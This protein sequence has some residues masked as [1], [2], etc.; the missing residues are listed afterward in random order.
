[1]HPK[2]FRK[3]LLSE[4]VYHLHGLNEES[5]SLSNLG[6]I[7]IFIG[8]NN[9]GKS[10]FLRTLFRDEKSKKINADL[11]L[12]TINAFINYQ[13][14]RI[15]QLYE[16]SLDRKPGLQIAGRDLSQF[17]FQN[18]S[19]SDIYPDWL[20]KIKSDVNQFHTQIMDGN[21][22]AMGN[23][24]V[25]GEVDAI[26][27][28]LMREVEKW[29]KQIGRIDVSRTKLYIPLL[30]GLRGFEFASPKS[31]ED[32]HDFYDRRTRKDYFNGKGEESDNRKGDI[33]TGLT[34]F[35]ETKAML[36]GD[37][38]DRQRIKEF[39]QFIGETFFGGPDFS[40]IPR[41]DDD[42]VHIKIGDEKDYPIHKLGDGIQAL[43]VLLFPVF[44]NKDK[45][46]SVFFEEPDQSLHPAFQR[47]FLEA[48]SRKEFE[49]CQFFFTTHSNHFLDMTL[50]FSNISVFSFRKNP[51]GEG[52]KFLVQNVESHDWNILEQLGVRNSSV[53]LSNC[54]IWVEGIT[55]RIYIRKYL[56][57]F[58][59]KNGGKFKE[60]LH[61]SFVEYGGGNI[62]HWSFLEENDDE[63]KNINVDKLC[64]KLF[65]VAD[66]D[67]TGQEVSGS[68]SKKK[69]RLEALRK[70]LGDRFHCWD[71]R[72]IE[73]T[74][75]LETIKQVISEFEDIDRDEIDFTGFD[76]KS[77]TNEP[78][79]KFID[80]NF[81]SKRKGKYAA[82]S[83]T[84][85]N[86]VKFAK[87][88]VGKISSFDDLSVEVKEFAE[89]LHRFIASN[90]R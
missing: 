72:E 49:H 80:E 2:L 59:N 76:G 87:I 24:W 3:I 60:D 79:G 19:Y 16:Q 10:T 88:A 26:A 39:E 7:N 73:N 14:R 12:E 71:S 58:Q 20:A 23:P 35:E 66:S 29:G 27:I 33:F 51:T 28:P 9:T 4:E 61:Y 45:N 85:S 37:Q 52:K 62:T 31:S 42:V 84:V 56:E 90:N 5:D 46:L 30:R 86:K 70:A 18:L 53:F 22:G 55:D 44:K 47:I 8:P 50:D 74:L 75:T 38:S 77:H 65:L 83:G 68:P 41:I 67:N 69:K 17:R 64:G 25:K 63:N 13:N 57:L 6:Q 78:L 32:N 81:S 82:E 34:L 48:L 1:M 11:D 43:I 21:R 40:I 89:K 15:L 54:T 36:L